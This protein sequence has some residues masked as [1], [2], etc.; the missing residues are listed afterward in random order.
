MVIGLSQTECKKLEFISLH[1]LPV[2]A[3]ETCNFLGNFFLTKGF[4]WKKGFCGKLKKCKFPLLAQ[5]V[6]VMK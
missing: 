6:C 4:I 1:T 2:P 3:V 5:G